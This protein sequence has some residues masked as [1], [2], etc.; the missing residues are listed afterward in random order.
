MRTLIE[1]RYWRC[2]LF[3]CFGLMAFDHYHRIDAAHFAAR[4]FSGDLD[5]WFFHQ[6]DDPLALAFGLL[7]DDAI[8]VRENIV[9]HGMGKHHRQ[10]ALDGT[11]EIGLAVL[12]TTLVIVAVFYPWLLWAGLSDAFFISLVWPFP[13]LCCCRYLLV[14]RLTRYCLRFGQTPDAVHQHDR[15][16]ERFISS[17]RLLGY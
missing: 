5:V 9:R 17:D 10:A 8:V 11:Q 6:H 13:P 7:I 16:N 12:A 4:Y 15:R 14:S 1:G 2:L 3:G